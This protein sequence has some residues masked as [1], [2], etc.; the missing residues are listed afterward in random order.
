M[1][2]QH[3]HVPLTL[4]EKVAAFFTLSDPG[5]LV[6]CHAAERQRVVHE[7]IML[8]SMGLLF[9]TIWT[10]VM[11]MFGIARFSALLIAV[12]IVAI[13]LFF[14]VR[15][16]ATDTHPRG[17]LRNGPYPR[18]FYWRLASRLAISVLLNVGT[19]VGVDLYI[20]RDEALKA[21]ALDV[22]A[23]NAP[24]RAEYER[25]IEALRQ[26][27]VV[28]AENRVKNLTGRLDVIVKG[29][30]AARQA[31]SDAFAASQAQTLEMRRQDDGFGDRLVGHGKLARDAQEQSDLAREQMQ[32]AQAR[33]AQLDGEQQSAQLQLDAA[34]GDL[35]SANKQFGKDKTALLVERDG[36]FVH[37]TS[38]PMAVVLGWLKL[39]SNVEIA[40]AVR[41]TTSI[42]FLTVMTLELAFFLCRVPFKG[43]QMH[44]V[45]L[46]DRMRREVVTLGADFAAQVRE[47]RQRAPLRV[48]ADNEDN[49][50][51]NHGQQ[52]PNGRP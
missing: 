51:D 12:L 22:E 8:C 23:K 28:P 47:A 20:M 30:A 24:I 52:Q 37:T 19:A 16:T 27:E 26:L 44:D 17:I 10:V 32:V 41:L 31:W 18:S 21:E 29:R 50:A 36:R 9:I 42:A 15:M 49:A 4:L 45:R 38:G 25:R 43:E 40:V 11:T 46:R 7:F 6:Q 35:S 2:E 1:A 34:R 48:V 3:E 39:Q 5:I 13:I 33:Q 14:D